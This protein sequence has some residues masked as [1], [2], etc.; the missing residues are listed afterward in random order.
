MT[1]LLSSIVAPEELGRRNKKTPTLRET[2]GGATLATASSPVTSAL[3]LLDRL[4]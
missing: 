3:A 4:D 1:A 2:H